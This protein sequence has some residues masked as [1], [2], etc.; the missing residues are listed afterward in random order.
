ML[1]ILRRHCTKGSTRERLPITTVKA[2]GQADQATITLPGHDFETGQAVVY[3][4]T[5]GSNSIPGLTAGTIYYVIRVDAN[6]IK[7]AVDIPNLVAGTGLNLT[8]PAKPMVGKN[9]YT[10]TPID[11]RTVN[12]FDPSAVD[13]TMHTIALPH[14]DFVTGQAVIYHSQG[15]ADV[16]G[17][18]NNATTMQSPPAPISSSWRRRRTTRTR[19]TRS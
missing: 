3:S 2:Q 18:I 19:A 16:P 7:L 6:T 4:V 5:T 8:A 9:G 1:K 15:G 14:H 12:S 10:L 13:G 11:A 17:L